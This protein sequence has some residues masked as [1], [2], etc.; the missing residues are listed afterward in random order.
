M[1][2]QAYG[3]DRRP[4]LHPKKPDAALEWQ[5]LLAD[6]L[7]TLGEDTYVPSPIQE[8]PKVLRD[9]RMAVSRSKGKAPPTREAT[10]PS[11]S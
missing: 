6:P 9:W 7:F 10:M 1:A 8:A 3:N 2:D 4:T 11:Q 5:Q